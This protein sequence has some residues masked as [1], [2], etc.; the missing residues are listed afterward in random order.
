MLSVGFEATPLHDSCFP[1]CAACVSLLCSALRL[2]EEMS[3]IGSDASTHGPSFMLGGEWQKVF[4]GSPIHP[5]L[6]HLGV[7]Q[8]AITRFSRAT[9]A[10]KRL[11][12]AVLNTFTITNLSVLLS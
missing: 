12:R 5:H 3:S 4:E 1:G 8:A 6:A 9:A 10:F 7:I 11:L 2:C